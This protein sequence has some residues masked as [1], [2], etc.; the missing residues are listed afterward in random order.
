LK[1]EEKRHGFFDVLSKVA[2][3]ELGKAQKGR[4][5]WLAQMASTIGALDGASRPDL[6]GVWKSMADDL[7]TGT[8]SEWDEFRSSVAD[9]LKAI[10]AHTPE[11]DR[12]DVCKGAAGCLS[13]AAVPKADTEAD[14]LVI[15]FS[16]KNWLTA[17]MTLFNAAGDLQS[18]SISIPGSQKFTLE[19]LQL[20]A[21]LDVNASIKARIRPSISAEELTA[22]I[23]AEIA[24]GRFLRAPAVFVPFVAEILNGKVDW[25]GIVRAGAERLRVTNIDVNECRSLTTLLVSAATIA[26][27]SKATAVLKELSSQGHLSHLLYQH[28]ENVDTRAVL[29][30][31]ILLANPAFERGAQIENSTNG[32]TVFNEAIAAPQFEA[33]LISAIARFVTSMRA[34]GWLFQIG[35]Q[36]AN[37]ARF[38]AA[39]IGEITKL[40]Y[41]FPIEPQLVIDHRDF[42]ER[43]E[44]LNP[45]K[46]FMSKLSKRKGLLNLLSEQ[47]FE[48]NRCYLYSA[49]LD[50]AKAFD[51]TPYFIFVERG[52]LLLDQAGW[53]KALGSTSGPHFDLVR[54]CSDLRNLGPDFNLSMSTRDA[55]VAQI[56]KAGKGKTGISDEARER[57]ATILSLVESKLRTSLMRDVLDDM[58]ASADKAEIGRTI[59]LAG[60]YIDLAEGCDVDR[61]VRRIFMPIVNAPDDRTVSWM[62]RVIENRPLFFKQLP[63]ESKGE[64]G[65]RIRTSLQTK[66]SLSQDILENL[67]RIAAILELDLDGNHQND[68]GTDSEDA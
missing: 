21:G 41:E 18:L 16:A 59:D 67:K 3:E 62:T 20:L 11:T 54:L 13:L 53:E 9:G 33:A 40:D 66:E 15:N 27:Y 31:A 61:I 44:E 2:M 68:S 51:D 35:A 6:G 24:A 60:D 25:E 1:N 52:I 19:V 28:R 57:L 38:V 14:P 26:N 49:V 32:D 17:A 48:V 22:A 43:H 5:T 50:G 37:I 42:L 47:P 45:A 46:N 39:I 65:L 29:Y 10:L 8:V 12:M 36:N 56:R 58:A 30:G 4:G 23:V 34:G 64:F 63:A 55:L 7:R